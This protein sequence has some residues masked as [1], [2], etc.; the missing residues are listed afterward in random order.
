MGKEKL[1]NKLRGAFQAPREYDEDILATDKLSMELMN[2]SAEGRI[3][4]LVGAVIDNYK[5]RGLIGDG[6]QWKTEEDFRKDLNGFFSYV[7][8]NPEEKEKVNPKRTE[9]P[10]V[11]Y[12]EPGFGKMN[13][14]ELR[15]ALKKDFDSY[16]EFKEHLKTQIKHQGKDKTLQELKES[17]DTVEPELSD[18]TYRLASE[19][20][21]E[22]GEDFII[23]EENQN[24]TSQ[25]V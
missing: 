8:G 25:A 6:G 20:F 18:L 1:L 5:T 7:L 9:S 3:D 23:P 17:I 21:S 24:G 14:K 10:P 22:M 12:S 4:D 16:R 15:E 19:A 2:L 11:Y 13:E